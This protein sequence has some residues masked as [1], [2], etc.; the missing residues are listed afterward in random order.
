MSKTENT[1]LIPPSNTLETAVTDAYVGYLDDDDDSDEV[2]DE[3][4]WIREQRA[5]NK[6]LPWMKRPSLWM[7]CLTL[8]FVAMASLSAEPLRTAIY[9]RLAC[10]SV[11]E[12][13]SKGVCDPIDLQILISNLS[14]CVLILAGLVT[15]VALGK[16]GQLSDQYGRKFFISLAIACVF[17]GKMIQYFLL[18]HFKVLPFRWIIITDIAVSAGGGVMTLVALT[19]SYISDVVELHERIYLLGLSIASLYV[20]LSIGPI[21]GNLLLA[22]PGKFLLKPPR[23]P[24]MAQANSSFTAAS[25]T[26]QELLLK[27][28]IP[29]KFELGLL[30][31]IFVYC[32]FVLPESRSKKASQRSRSMSRSLTHSNLSALAEEGGLA[33]ADECAVASKSVLSSWRS[34][35]SFLKPLRLITL[36]ADSVSP[37]RRHRLTKDR[38]T[39]YIL[40]FIDCIHISYSLLFGN[41]IMLYGVYKFQWNSTD[42]GHFMAVACLARATVLIVL[43]PIILHSLLHKR[44]GFKIFKR[45]FDMVDFSMGWL[46]MA[47][48]CIGFWLLFVAN[49]TSAIFVVLVVQSFNLLA[50]PT[51]NSAIIKH[52]PESK[53]GEFFGATLILK[54][55]MSLISP[56]VFVS[57]Y[58]VSV[59]RWGNP[60]LV[61]A[62]F[63]VLSLLFLGL[64]HL[65]KHLLNLSADSQESEMWRDDSRRNSVSSFLSRSSFDLRDSMDFSSLESPVNESFV[66]PVQGSSRGLHNHERSNSFCRVQNQA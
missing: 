22:I 13:S 58:K 30:V 45:Q 44:F 32:V 5:H 36:P 6:S 47:A 62:V 49:S 15:M 27:E 20:G 10:N 48:E 1:P 26:F 3:V 38:I 51:F 7:V 64:L 66:S 17:V 37:S 16:I 39:V 31:T 34:L 4:L 2:D 61:F 50:T 53:I 35:F 12:G 43:S 56:L 21:I 52:F 46:G 33:D 18:R 60:Q 41:I 42:L 11:I 23:E 24:G 28:F 63:G 9:F 19:N 65:L 55:G 14:M 57:F 8:F 25:N 40:L 59:S 29:L 54:N